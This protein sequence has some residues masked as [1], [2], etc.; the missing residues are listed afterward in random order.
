MNP[1]IY[2]AVLLI[3]YA[4]GSIPTALLY[5]RLFHR[6][7]IRALGDGNMG[8]RNTRRQFGFNAGVIVAL[9]DIIKGALAVLLSMALN[10]PLEWQILTAIAVILGHDFP[11]FASF[12]GGQ[13]LAVTTGV[14]LVFFPWPTL[15]GF[16]IY[17]FLFL[18]F[19]NSDVAAGF[20]MGVLVLQEV[21]NQTPLLLVTFS[22]L[23]LLFIP[24]KQWLDK[25]RRDRIHGVTSIPLSQT[26][27]ENEKTVN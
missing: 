15:L 7:D 23:A 5:S 6:K 13:G 9:I 12:L 18:V 19:H 25:P 17:A 10:L 4:L 1:L 16:V 3:A 22:I 27:E 26:P 8:A 2:G 11:A 14:F 21:L 20:G 24:F